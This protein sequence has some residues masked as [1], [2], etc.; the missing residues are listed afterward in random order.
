MKME[1]EYSFETLVMFYQITWRYN[2]ENIILH[3]IPREK[4]KISKRIFYPKRV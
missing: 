4:P 2:R 1:A 3:S